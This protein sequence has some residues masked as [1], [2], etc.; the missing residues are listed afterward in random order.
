MEFTPLAKFYT[1]AGSDSRDKS[2]ICLKLMIPKQTTNFQRTQYTYLQFMFHV[3]VLSRWSRFSLRCLG[4]G[5]FSGIER[6]NISDD[7]LM[8]L[9]VAAAAHKALTK[10]SN[11]V[12]KSV[13]IIAI[14]TTA[15]ITKIIMPSHHRSDLLPDLATTI[16]TITITITTQ[17]QQKQQQQQKLQQER[18]KPTTTTPSSPELARVAPNHWWD[19]SSIE[20]WVGSF[21]HMAWHLQWMLKQRELWQWWCCE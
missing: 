2:H 17:L 20:T 11:Q 7:K 19:F 10:L 16:T 5:R 3:S 14:I 9:S 12:F 21:V 18:Q 8:S 13:C 4:N 1:A 15:T 6:G